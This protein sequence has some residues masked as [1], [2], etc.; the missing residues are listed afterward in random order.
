[1]GPALSGTGN[2]N[3][4]VNVDPALVPEGPVQTGHVTVNS[5]GGDASVEIRF[6]RQSSSNPGVIG[7]FTN[8]AGTSC[9]FVDTGGLVP[10]HFFHMYTGG[11]TASQWKLDLGGLP[12]T[13]LGDVWPFPTAIGSS[14]YGVSIG[15]GS[16]Q[17]SPI[18]IG[19]ANFMGSS[20]PACSLI[21][22][23]ADPHAPSGR[24]EGVDCAQN[25]TYPAGGHGR[26]NPD[27]TCICGHIPVRHTTWGAIKAMYQDD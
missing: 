26:V 6:V 9:N 4:T 15:Y 17:T 20:A 11:A 27:A 18:H 21:R 2:A 13:H 12:W 14:I 25:K 3:V 10:V 1:V 22:I 24:I 7:V 23:V 16:C 8:T 19:S 5:N